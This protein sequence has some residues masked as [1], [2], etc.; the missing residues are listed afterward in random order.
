[1]VEA[2]IVSILEFCGTYEM[3]LVLV[4]YCKNESVNGKD[5][6]R[7]R[8]QGRYFCGFLHRSLVEGTG[9][10]VRRRKFVKM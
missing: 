4:N 1:M 5:G 2:P 3:L 7:I 8:V 6:N 9:H 10:G